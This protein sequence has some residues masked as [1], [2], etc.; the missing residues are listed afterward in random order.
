MIDSVIEYSFVFKY[1]EWNKREDLDPWSIRQAALYH[2]YSRVDNTST[3]ILL[4]PEADSSIETAL[5]ERCKKFEAG[6]HW[7]AH[8]QSVVST[9]FDFIGS[10]QPVSGVLRK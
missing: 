1:A 9:L 10:W 4:S 8:L 5:T 3:Y 7:P 6:G 2:Q